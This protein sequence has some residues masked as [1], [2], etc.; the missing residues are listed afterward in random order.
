MSLRA[1]PAPDMRRRGG[2]G[3]QGCDCGVAWR[4]VWISVMALHWPRVRNTMVALYWPQALLLCP[5][6]LRCYLPNSPT[7]SGGTF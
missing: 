4:E 1:S 7:R 2:W 6:R 5:M 3:E